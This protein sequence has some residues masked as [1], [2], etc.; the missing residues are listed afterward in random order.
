MHLLLRD[1]ELEF[2]QLLNK[3][4]TIEEQWFV[5]TIKSF[6][7]FPFTVS[8]IVNDPSQKEKYS[9]MLA[10]VSQVFRAVSFFHFQ[11]M[12]PFPAFVLH[13]F[14]IETVGY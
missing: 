13:F 2:P 3:L 14:L 4:L 1:A 12:I 10:T 9:Q 5:V 8:K 6:Q 11:Y 7:A